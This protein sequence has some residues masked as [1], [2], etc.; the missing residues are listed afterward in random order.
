[1]PMNAY[2]GG[3]PGVPSQGG[4]TPPPGSGGGGWGPPPSGGGY[5]GPP[6]G[7][8]P[9]QPP[10]KKSKVG[11]F[12]GLGCGCLLLIGCLIGGLAAMGGGLAGMMGPGEEVAS[13]QITPGQ[14]FAV[15]YTQSGSQRY[16]AWLE[17][18]V[19]YTAGY[20]LNGNVL[21]AENGTAFG[22][23]TMDEDGEGSPIQERSDVIR[24]GWTST[25]LNGSG[26]ASGTVSLFPIPARTDGG[27]VT[28][29][30]TISSTPGM[31]GTIRLI[32][33]KRD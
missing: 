1:M 31:T 9:Q 28:I 18:D 22:Q 3:P 29:S 23:Y 4:G 33:A 20:Q 15:T 11:L 16:K 21:L 24:T 26:N 5:G 19:S 7:Y 10:P 6:P 27:T 8:P 32:V 12:V 2:P 17:V 25:N 14:P 13:A 30:G